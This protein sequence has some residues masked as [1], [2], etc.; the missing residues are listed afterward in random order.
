MVDT[1]HEAVTTLAQQS[2]DP[3]ARG[4][5][6][7]SA[8]LS[9]AFM[10]LTLCWGVL[11]ATGWVRSV[12]GRKAL[13]SGH[14]TLATL[15]LSFGCL[16]ALGFLYLTVNPFSLAYITVPFMPG[17]LAR[18]TFGIVGLE[19]M[20]AIALTT[21][22]QRWTSYRRW[23]W[24]HRLA[25]PAVALTALHAFFGAIANGHLATLWLAGITLL[26][27]PVTLALLRF[28]PPRTLERIGLVEEQV[29]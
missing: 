23:L 28:L 24:L 2:T 19:L 20:L 4:I 18:H 15:A 11:T 29:A 16:H 14:L 22:V 26:V 10:C 21:C 27:P 13:R 9:Y 5:A 25:Y 6:A 3:A 7:L 8:R 12:T 1:V 17:T